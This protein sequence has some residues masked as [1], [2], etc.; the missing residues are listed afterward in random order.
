MSSRNGKRHPFIQERCENIY[1]IKTNPN[2]M[3]AIR[4]IMA[5]DCEYLNGTAICTMF[6]LKSPKKMSMMNYQPTI[7]VN[8]FSLKFSAEVLCPSN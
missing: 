3:A 5:A 7:K 8:S 2:K 1:Q 6:I 4:K